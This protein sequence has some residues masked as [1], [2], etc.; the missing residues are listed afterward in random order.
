MKRVNATDAKRLVDEGW[1]YV[2][3]R[4]PAEFAAGHPEGAINIPFNAPDFADQ[5]SK[6]FPKK[7]AKVVIGCQVG[8]RSM[9]ASAQLEGQGYTELA[10]NSA[11]F[12]GWSAQKLPTAKGN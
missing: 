5:F 8:G 9:R 12:D 11:G 7:D 4:T 10:D 1:A 2:D 6:R 3:V